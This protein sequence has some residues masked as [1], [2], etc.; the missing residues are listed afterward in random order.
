VT[1]PRL[2]DHARGYALIERDDGVVYQLYGGSI[3]LST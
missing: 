1:F 2:P 3:R